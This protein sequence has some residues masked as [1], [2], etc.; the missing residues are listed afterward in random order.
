MFKQTGRFARA[1]AA[2]VI[3]AAPAELGRNHLAAQGTTATILGTVTDSSGAAV[4]GA[5][6]QVRN[7]GTAITQSVASDEQGRFRVPDLS[8]GDY[9]VQ[10]AKMGFQTVVHKGITLTVGSQ[11]VIDFSLPVGQ[12]QQTVTVEG[13]VTQVDTTNA[14]VG[15]LVDQRQMREL[16]LNG[17]NFE[18]LIQLAPGM[19]LV[20]SVAPNARQGAAKS[21]SAAGARP[22]QQAVLLDDENME[23]FYKRGFGT[24]TGSSL[25]VEAIAEFQ[26]LTNTYGAQFGGNGV[27]INSVSK[28]GTNAFHGSAYDFLRNSALDA[29]NFFDPHSLPAFRK[30]QFGG[31]VGGPVKKDKAF[32]FANYEGIQQLLGETKIAMVPACNVSGTCTITATNSATAQAIAQTLALYPTPT[33]I[34]SGGIGELTEVANQITHENYFL[35]RFDYALS[36]KD[37]F[38]LRYLIDKQHFLEPFPSSG[39]LLP[40]WPETDTGN[41]QFSTFEWKRIISP[42]LLNTARLSFSRPGTT[43]ASASTTPALQFFPGTGRPDAFVGI[44]GLTSLGVSTFDPS[45]QVQ[46]K[47]TEADDLLWTHGAHTTRFGVSILR[48]DSN[49]YYPYRSGSSWSFQS[50]SNFLAGTALSVVGTPVGAQYYPNRQYRETDPTPYVQDDWKVTSKLALNLGLRWDFT[51]NAVDAHNAFYAV[52]DF[53]TGT[54]FVNVPHA[55]RSNPSWRNW[56]PRFGFAYDVFADHKT[57]VRGGFG[58]TH[59]PIFPGNYNSSYTGAPPWNSFQQNSPTYPVPFSTL[60]PSLPTESPGWN[61]YNDRTPYLIQYNL[62][63]QREISEGTVLS[64]GYVGSHGVDLLTEQEQNPVIPTIDSNGVYHF[65]SLVNGKVVGNPRQDPNLSVFPEAVPGTTSR[66]NSLQTSLNRRFTR[67]VQAQLAYTY[68]KCIDDGGSPVGSLNGGNSPA[69]YENPYVRAIDR[70]LCNF[71]TTHALRVNGLVA[72][73]FHGN[74]LVEGWQLSGIVTANTGLPFTVSTGFDQVGYAGSGTPRPNLNP[75]FSPNPAVGNVNEWFNPAAFSLQPVG[76]LGN[77]GRDTVIGP[78]I[79]DADLA[80]LKNTKVRESVNIQF[81]WEVFNIFNHP[82]FGLPGANMFTAGTN[83]GG[84]PNPTAGQITTTVTSSRQMQFGLK[85]IF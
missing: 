73:P 10:A 34:L 64:V 5:A 23:N 70:G 61:W 49:V 39:S 78:G 56:D 26:T 85:L 69:S 2:I 22:E 77:L 47:F 30:N 67:N 36:E 40:L 75:G 33:T 51:T 60:T 29:R 46:N 7:V 57:S 76:T 38:F 58:I 15:A 28:S 82:N 25:G 43:Q 3:M 81:R 63:V 37:S 8:L 45:A 1:L 79:V 74:R 9:E 48:L 54:G 4:P 71:N 84:N 17:R 20:T 80:L 68:S 27:V 13:Q 18:Q 72:L 14:A 11:S 16:P 32:F 50:L 21:F 65:G 53:V 35:G 66:Y 59:S 55:T 44:T 41:N 42:T 62:N 24:V 19:Q 83:G 6:I 52:T 31:S 12:A